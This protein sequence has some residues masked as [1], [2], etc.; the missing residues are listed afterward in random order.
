[1]ATSKFV[2]LSPIV[3]ILEPED[4]LD[5]L[6]TQRRLPLIHLSSYRRVGRHFLEEFFSGNLCRDEAV[7]GVKYLETK[8][9]F[10]DGQVT[11]LAQVSRVNVR[12]SIALSSHGFIHVGRKI[13]F[14]LVRLNDVAHSQDVDVVPVPASK[15]PRSL[16]AT[17]L[18]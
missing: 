2:V 13:A 18:A 16:L 7:G 8:T 1:M 17:D 15:S 14:V 5:L 10:L 6:V 9:G 12:P 4:V 11:H 3:L